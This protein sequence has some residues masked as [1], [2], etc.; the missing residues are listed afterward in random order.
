MIPDPRM[1]LTIPRLERHVPAAR[2]RRE[3]LADLTASAGP[4][5]AQ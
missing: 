1:A 4:E 3:R 5:A 2:A